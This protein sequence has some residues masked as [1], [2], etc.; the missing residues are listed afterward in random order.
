[1]LDGSISRYIPEKYRVKN[2]VPSCEIR[3]F[4]ECYNLLQIL[5]AVMYLFEYI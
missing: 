4:T 1:M 3:I 5:F 2:G